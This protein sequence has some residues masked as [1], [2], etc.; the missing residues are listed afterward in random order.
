[1]LLRSKPAKISGCTGAVAS[2]AV[3]LLLLIL[4]LVSSFACS[5]GQVLTTVPQRQCADGKPLVQCIISPCDVINSPCKDTEICETNYCGACTAVCKPKG[6]NS[7][8]SCSNGCPAE[9]AALG[10]P[11][12]SVT[13]ITRD[14][15]CDALCKYKESVK[16]TGPC[17]GSSSTNGSTTIVAS[18][19][20]TP[21]HGC[22]CIA[23]YDPVCTVQ[24]HTK[25]NACQ[26]EC[27]NETVAYRGECTQEQGAVG[28]SAVV[29]GTSGSA[30]VANASSPAVSSG[31]SMKA[32]TSAA[33]LLLPRLAGV[34]I[35]SLVA[36]A[37]LFAVL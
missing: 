22:V 17:N 4:A 12:C 13:G 3:P 15:A 33:G 18:S 29:N 5:S 32:A 11:V 21:R 30:G 24:N 37:L 28:P 7:T 8:V 23:L 25:S 14:T 34:V 10:G 1:M 35:K 20:S 16:H 36:A 26:A 27:V 2:N 31:T 9:Y 6:L 19:K